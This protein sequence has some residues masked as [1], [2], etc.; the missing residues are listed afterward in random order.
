LFIP[1]APTKFSRIWIVPHPATQQPTLLNN[2]SA[3][4]IAKM[5][6]SVR[7]VVERNLKSFQKEGLLE[8]SRKQLQIKDLKLLKEKIQHIFPI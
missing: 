1:T 8:R 2:L 3:T 4:E 5:I 7:Q 6:G